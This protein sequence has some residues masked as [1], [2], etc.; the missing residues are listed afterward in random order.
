[1]KSLLDIPDRYAGSDPTPYPQSGVMAVALTFKPLP[2]PAK[3][4]MAA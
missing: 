2:A 4:R 1:M 3:L